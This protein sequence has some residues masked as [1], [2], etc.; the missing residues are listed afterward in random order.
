MR[1]ECSN[2]RVVT[3]CRRVGSAGFC[4]GKRL[5][6]ASDE[7]GSFISGEADA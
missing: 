1:M 7:L 3:Y 4:F 6:I 2:C 5:D